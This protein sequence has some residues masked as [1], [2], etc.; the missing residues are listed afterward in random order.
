MRDLNVLSPDLAHE[1]HVVI[2]WYAQRRSGIDRFHYQTHNPGDL[3]PSINEI[4]DK[5]ELT[6]IRMIP[7][8][9]GLLG[10]AEHFEQRDQFVITSVNVAADVEGTVLIITV[11]P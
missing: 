2:S 11:V 1:F 4:A 9:T 8:A 7:R 5:Y 10:V 3:W 6:S